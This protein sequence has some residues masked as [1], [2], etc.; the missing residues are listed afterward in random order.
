MCFRQRNHERRG[1][2]GFCERRRRRRA[3]GS[4]RSSCVIEQRLEKRRQQLR[5][6]AACGASDLAC[7]ERQRI[8]EQVDDAAYLMQFAQC[9]E[10]F[11]VNALPRAQCHDGEFGGAA[12]GRAEQRFDFLQV[13]H[14]LWRKEDAGE[15]A[16]GLC[17]EAAFLQVFCAQNFKTLFI[18]S[19]E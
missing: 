10:Q 7:Y 12:V 16:M 14:C 11:R 19:L 18:Q 13:R 15:A 5:Q 8:L 6:I 4:A 9:R 2:Q 1:P 3:R 17:D